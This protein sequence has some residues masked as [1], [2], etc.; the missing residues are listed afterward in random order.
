[1]TFPNG[2]EFQAAPCEYPSWPI[3]APNKE[4]TEPTLNGWIENSWFYAPGGWFK[5]LTADWTVPAVPT[6]TYWDDNQTFFTF[7]G[8]ERFGP[9][10]IIQP[11][12]QFGHSA[13]GGGNY[14][15]IS[16]WYCGPSCFHSNLVGVS[17]GNSLH[18][19]ISADCDPDLNCLWNITA[20]SSSGAST[21][22]T[23]ADFGP[24]YIWATGG[25]L[26]VYNLYFCGYLPPNGPTVFSNI[27]LFDQDGN[28]LSPNWGTTVNGGTPNCSFG[29]GTS[30]DSTALYYSGDCGSCAGAQCGD[31]DAC[32]RCCGGDCGPTAYC[33]TF[34]ECHSGN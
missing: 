9:T 30:V 11:V 29:V 22:L 12:L 24:A 5:R 3:R 4:G 28:P 1:V 19:T 18:G 27:S 33:D 20:D 2:A 23:L 31:R 21:R 8:L 14:W 32:G 26:E 34:C 17:A 25:A 13:A 15:A 16:S 6:L 7:P 10:A